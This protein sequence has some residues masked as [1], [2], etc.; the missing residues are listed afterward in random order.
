MAATCCPSAQDERGQSGPETIQ[1]NETV[2]ALAQPVRGYSG[3][4]VG[5]LDAPP[6]FLEM[7][8][9]AIYAC[10]ADGRLLWHNSRAVD[11]WGRTPRLADDSELFCGSFKLFFDGREIH[12]D[13]TPMAHVLRTGEA[14]RDAEGIIERPDGSRIWAMVHIAP[15]RNDAGEVVGAINCFHDITER[16]RAEQALRDS[17]QRSRDLLEALPAAIYTTDAAGRITFYNQAAVDLSGR[18]PELG[19]DE[20]CVTWRLY[21]TDGTPLPHDE[22]PMAVALKENRPVRDAEAVAERPDGTR[23]PFIPYPTPL[24]DS[25]GALI[26]AVNML[27]DISE[28][29]SA[30]TR[31]KAL[32]AELDH[33]V[34]NTLATVQSIAAQTIGREGNAPGP[35]RDFERRLFALSSVHD[36][37]S[38][39]GWE[40]AELSAVLRDLFAP[41]RTAEADPIR[42]SG[43]PLPLA[44]KVAVTLAMVLHELA[45]NAIKYGALSQPPGTVSVA[46]RVE[47]NGAEPLLSIDWVESGGPVVVKPE[48]CGFGLRL[49]ER[50][51]TKELK[52]AAEMTF[53]PAG[54]RASIR[55]PM[56]PSARP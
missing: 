50:G 6:A 38:Q 22:C 15:V 14:V 39:G 48:R 28:R 31:Q 9:V 1:M 13:E 43:D 54:V 19:T 51:I 24:R 2:L 42:L 44:P 18:R 33:R 52:G 8:P 26:G 35:R 46:W 3:P 45:T 20:W 30:E 47:Q 36:H 7:L 55:I 5:L 11:L 32:L 17:E 49:L 4:L 56:E 29:K 37:L 25:S 41:F 23:I 34:K 53:N 16:K 27:V 40:A 10:D 12:R 21:N